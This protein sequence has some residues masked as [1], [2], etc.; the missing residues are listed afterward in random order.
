M[1]GAGPA[2]PTAMQQPSAKAESAKGRM[3][4]LP[5]SALE[6]LVNNTAGPVWLP[7]CQ[8]SFRVCPRR[9]QPP[10]GGGSAFAEVTYCL[11]CDCRRLHDLPSPGILTRWCARSN[12]ASFCGASAVQACAFKPVLGQR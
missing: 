1:A 12:V 9:G 6:V 2:R 5:T 10:G 11:Q 4:A 3:L 8:V 7:F